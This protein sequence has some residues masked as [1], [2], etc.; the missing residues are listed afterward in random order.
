[1]LLARLNRLRICPAPGIARIAL[2]R[3]HKRQKK[4]GREGKTLPRIMRRQVLVSSR[5]LRSQ[6]QSHK[7]CSQRAHHPSILVFLFERRFYGQ[8]F[9]P[10][11]FLPLPCFHRQLSAVGVLSVSCKVPAVARV[12]SC[13]QSL[14]K[15]GPQKVPRDNIFLKFV[16]R[17]AKCLQIALETLGR[18]CLPG[19]SPM[20]PRCF[21]DD[22]QVS[23]AE[24]SRVCWKGKTC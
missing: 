17:L 20:P 23:P 8:P 13:K 18:P 12:S 2:R 22:L 9:A 16:F 3:P 19:A 10:I 15:L 4:T 14:L 5:M 24:K 7:P 1:L 21:S 11:D 6:A